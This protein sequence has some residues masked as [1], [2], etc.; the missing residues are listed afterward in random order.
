MGVVRAWM[1]VKDPA[2]HQD[3][4][5]GLVQMTTHQGPFASDFLP[6]YKYKSRR[7]LGGCLEGSLDKAAGARLSIVSDFRF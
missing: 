7:T 5:K 6:V 4:T 1:G 2:D 3:H